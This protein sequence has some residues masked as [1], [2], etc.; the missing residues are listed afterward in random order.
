MIKPFYELKLY[1]VFD[2]I[3][4]FFISSLLFII[5][6]IPFI[7]FLYMNYVTGSF[8]LGVYVS[9]ILI[10]PA[11]LA[12]ISV[13]VNAV[14][15]GEFHKVAGKFFKSYKENFF[16][17]IYYFAVVAVIMYML[18]FDRLNIARLIGYNIKAVSIIFLIAEVIVIFFSIMLFLVVSRFYIKA[19][20]A[21]KL[22][23]FY[24]VKNFKNIM[25]SSALVIVL[26]YI[27]TY[28]NAFFIILSTG[29]VYAVVFLLKNSLIEIEEKYYKNK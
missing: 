20:Q 27:V 18:N 17:G 16:E 28:V 10:G 9:A 19:K 11:L 2:H 6:N 23:I 13:M 8:L 7:M 3:Y 22:S 26:G 21:I 12:V 14:V 4:L 1:T 25:L 15:N 29:A 5:V 24:S